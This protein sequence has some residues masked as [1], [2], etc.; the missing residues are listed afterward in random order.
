[1]ISFDLRCTLS[2]SKGPLDL[3]LQGSINS[4]QI[5]GL[6]GPSG[7]GK[8]SLLSMLAGLLPPERGLLQ[9]GETTWLDTTKKIKVPIMRRGI[10]YLPQ[11]YGLFP[12]MTIWQQLRYAAPK[13]TPAA[14]LEEYLE[15]LEI[16]ALRHQR[17]GLLSGGQQQ[18]AALARVMAQQPRLLLLDEP[19]SALDA[20]LRQK[21]VA[22][23]Q[24][25]QKTHPTPTLLVA[26]QLEVLQQ[27]ADE[28]W[29]IRDGRL[30]QVTYTDEA[31]KDLSDQKDRELDELRAELRRVKAELASLRGR[32]DGRNRK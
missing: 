31:T 25:Y 28:V 7:I 1:M 32:L 18:R 23:L 3:H 29:T 13:G 27:L 21:A 6:Y 24:T 22:L 14:V 4:Q 11:D 26:H 15:S 9:W 2:G 5:V 10:G 12:N 30:G 19:F 8:T 20:G 16:F 17:P